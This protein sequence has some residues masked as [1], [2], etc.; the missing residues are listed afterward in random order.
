MDM[1]TSSHQPND[2][3][4]VSHQQS[5]IQLEWNRNQYQAAIKMMIWIVAYGTLL[6]TLQ[7]LP[8]RYVGMV[9]G[10][11]AAMYMTGYLCLYPNSLRNRSGSLITAICLV[12][13]VWLVA[14]GSVA[15]LVS[16]IIE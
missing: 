3:V 14:I 2:L 12:A 15:G 16:G 6:A 1:N 8:S 9:L 4:A 7:Y 13:F 5:R 10:I 11:G